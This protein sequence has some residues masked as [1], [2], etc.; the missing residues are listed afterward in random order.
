MSDYV[1]PLPL[2]CK[3]IDIFGRIITLDWYDGITSGLAEFLSH[4]TAIRFDLL[5]WGPAQER[6]VF[7][8]SRLN[9][10][11]F[12]QAIDLLKQRDVPSWPRWDLP[13]P[14]EQ[15]ESE[16]LSRALDEILKRSVG[17]E[18]AIETDSMFETV[19]AAKNLDQ[20]PQGLIP[21]HFAPYPLSDD[22]EF[23]HR[24]VAVTQ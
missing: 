3:T 6:R 4:G 13:W 2:P 23:W 15:D 9:P 11:A 22:Y 19:F 14:K 8:L 5:A 10:S 18:Y 24:F 21:E 20:I 16:R 17:P 1:V 7:T 12:E